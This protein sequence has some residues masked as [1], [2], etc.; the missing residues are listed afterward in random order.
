MKIYKS[1]Y[2]YDLDISVSEFIT[3]QLIANFCKW[4]KISLPKSAF[5]K[6]EYQENENLKS[7]GKRYGAEISYVHDLLKVFSPTVLMQYISDKGII[8]FRMVKVETRKRYLIDLVENQ[9]KYL[10]TL[11]IQE[12]QALEFEDNKVEYIANQNFVVKTK[13][14]KKKNI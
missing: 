11:E 7:L 9:I 2:V 10:K 4:Q 5:W 8:G 6:K 3:E 1:I 12:S 14:T 13:K